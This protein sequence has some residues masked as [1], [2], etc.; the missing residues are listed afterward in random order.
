MI[1]H[2]IITTKPN[3]P[4]QHRNANKKQFFMRATFVGFSIPYNM[5]NINGLV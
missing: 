1:K 3:W 2:H 4:K 5:I